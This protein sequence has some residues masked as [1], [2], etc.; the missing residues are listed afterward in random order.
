MPKPP[1]RSAMDSW[2]PV[3]HTA[4]FHAAVCSL[5]HCSIDRWGG[6][7]IPS[8]MASVGSFFIA[9]CRPRIWLSAQ[10]MSTVP[11]RSPIRAKARTSSE[12]CSRTNRIVS[13][14]F[15]IVISWALIARLRSAGRRSPTLKSKKVK[16]KRVKSRG[17]RVLP[18]L[19]ALSPHSWRPAF[20]PPGT[21]FSEL[22]AV[23]NELK[24]GLSK[25]GG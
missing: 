3:A 18:E 12:A 7:T 8:V 14:F 25:Y 4:A 21:L 10:G 23:I 22:G 15:I 6:Y 20:T 19:W 17:Q 1:V 5:E 24:V 9:V 16:R 13:S 2:A 11:R